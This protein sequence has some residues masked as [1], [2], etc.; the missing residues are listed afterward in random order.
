V[1][2]HDDNRF[3][4][5]STRRS[6]EDTD[7][8][9]MDATDARTDRML[10]QLQGGGWEATDWSPDNQTLLVVQEVS[11]NESYLWLVNVSTG[12]KK[13]LTPKAGTEEVD[14]E[15]LCVPQTLGVTV[16]QVSN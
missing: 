3:A 7:L 9:V 8:W 5:S 12:E 4:Y 15:T 1:Y 10:L 6:G 11:A 14:T 16:A 13:M 2:A